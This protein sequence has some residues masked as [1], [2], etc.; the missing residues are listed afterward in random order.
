MAIRD[1]MRAN[2]ATVV[3]PGETIQQVFAAQTTSPYSALISYWI[4]IFKNAYRVVVVTDQRI[5]VCNAGRAS[6]TAVKGVVGEFPR[7]TK[8]GPPKG[9]WY[10]CE[11]LGPK[12]YIH[13]RFHKDVIAAD[14]GATA[15]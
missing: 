3:N 8:I 5:L 6:T 11:T 4:V 2:A 13:K 15:S 1:K 12:L 14:A 7:S 10:K 9:V